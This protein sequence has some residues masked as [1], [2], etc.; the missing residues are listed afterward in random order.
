MTK[1]NGYDFRPVRVGIRSFLLSDAKPTG[2][3]L[4]KHSGHLLRLGPTV[5]FPLCRTN[6]ALLTLVFRG[7]VVQ[8]ARLLRY[9]CFRFW[10]RS[11]CG[12]VTVPGQVRVG[13]GSSRFSSGVSNFHPAKDR[14]GRQPKRLFPA[15]AEADNISGRA[16]VESS[17]CTS[18]RNK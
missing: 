2:L 14:T 7:T 4:F 6:E 10:F 5:T 8:T 3:K 15:G 18:L 9:W 13:S 1:G 17:S 16:E 11:A 12:S